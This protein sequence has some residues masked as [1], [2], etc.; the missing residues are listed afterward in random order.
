MCFPSPCPTLATLHLSENKLFLSAPTI[1]ACWCLSF[2]FAQAQG[3]GTT[4]SKSS[5]RWTR[6][7]SPSPPAR[8]LLYKVSSLLRGSHKAWGRSRWGMKHSHTLCHLP[9]PEGPQH[10]GH[11]ANKHSHQCQPAALLKPSAT[12]HRGVSQGYCSLG[13]PRDL[14]RAFFKPRK[15]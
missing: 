7:N 11:A 8:E 3:S 1:S 12:A 10:R 15:Q 6:S 5:D 9:P 13:S 14:L 2:V 4:T